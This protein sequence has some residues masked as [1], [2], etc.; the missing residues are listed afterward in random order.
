L[1]NNYDGER[2]RLKIN[3]IT[4]ESTDYFY[5]FLSSTFLNFTAVTHPTGGHLDVF[6]NKF[7][8]LENRITFG[9][10]FS[11]VNLDPMEKIYGRGGMG[12][13]YVFAILDWSSKGMNNVNLWVDQEFQHIPASR[14]K[15]GPNQRL[16]NVI[17]KEF[18]SVLVNDPKYISRQRCT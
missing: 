13:Q 5:Q 4:S 14:S 7:E 3:R 16:T 15:F 17:W 6:A 11:C 2:L 18:F 12:S 10:D 9:F 1:S 8:S